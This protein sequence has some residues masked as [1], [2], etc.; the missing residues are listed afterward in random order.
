MISEHRQSQTIKIIGNLELNYS[1]IYLDSLRTIKRD[2]QPKSTVVY[3]LEMG[4][5]SLST[6]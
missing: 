5:F 1:L 2:K 3:L 6:V 4:D